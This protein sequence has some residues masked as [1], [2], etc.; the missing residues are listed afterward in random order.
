MIYNTVARILLCWFLLLSGP[1]QTEKE[2]SIRWA[3]SDNRECSI[4]R[5]V[6]WI[7]SDGTPEKWFVDE[8][9]VLRLGAGDV[10]DIQWLPE[11]PENGRLEILLGLT[12]QGSEKV[13]KFLGDKE[14]GWALVFIGK[15]PVA[16]LA[17]ATRTPIVPLEF[18]E[19]PKIVAEIARILGKRV[20][21]VPRG[22]QRERELGRSAIHC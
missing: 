7:D 4:C 19:S 9:S 5:A 12:E 8:T 18:I 20:E 13:G 17:F 10:S 14:F 2:I 22:C 16:Q 11:D 21:G 3:S 1:T 6:D 15:G